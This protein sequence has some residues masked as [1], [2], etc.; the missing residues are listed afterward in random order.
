MP[1]TTTSATA[2]TVGAPTATRRRRRWTTAGLVLLGL[3]AA[4][5][6]GSAI[7]LERDSPCPPRRPAAAPDGT[8][9]MRAITAAC[10]GSADVLALDTLPK[11]TPAAGQLL[12]RVHAASLN[13]VDWHFMHGTPYIMRMDAGVGRPK[14]TRIGTDFSGVVEAV[15]AGVAG[16]AVGDAVFGTRDGALADYVTVRATGGVAHV[17]A[18]LATADAAAIPVAAVTA[19]QAVRDKAHVQA[20]QRVLVNGASGGVGTFAVQIAKAFGAEVTGVSSTRNLALVQSIGAD[21]AI[22]Y[23]REDFTATGQRYDVIIDAVGNRSLGELRRTLTSD[24][25][26]VL[27][28]GGGPEDS[29]LGPIGGML[30]AVVY[31]RFVSQRFVPFIAVV[32]PAD[33]QALATLIRDGKVRPVIDRRYPLEQTAEAMR[34]LEAGHARGKVLVTVAAESA[35]HSH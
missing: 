26:C 35:P 29:L 8:T 23:T 19:L 16:F 22:D 18:G 14:D 12:I 4:G 11:P 15:G 6:I 20:G 7:V 27:V 25:T 13:P 28:G 21:H 34:Y 24:G 1:D 30:G 2:S 31:T 9:T 32:T 33:L 10:Y 17:P 3:V 5:A